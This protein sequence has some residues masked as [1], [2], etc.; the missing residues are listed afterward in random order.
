M[1]GPSPLRDL[2]AGLFVLVGL[3]AVAF[4]AFRVGQAPFSEP[5]GFQ[6]Y[7]HFDQVGGLKQLAPVEIAGVK[8]GRVASIEPIGP[9]TMSFSMSR[10]ATP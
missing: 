3:I 6:L 10:S 2:V 5:G 8:V 1:T 7:A 4:L 9:R